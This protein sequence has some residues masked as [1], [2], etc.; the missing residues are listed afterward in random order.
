MPERAAVMIVAH[1]MLRDASI[2]YGAALISRPTAIARPVLLEFVARLGTA[3]RKLGA[4]AEVVS[5][6]SSDD[7]ILQGVLRQLRATEIVIITVGVVLNRSLAG[8]VREVWKTLWAARGNAVDAVRLLK[9][10]ERVMNERALPASQPRDPE[11]MARLA[12]TLP[13]MFKA[14]APKAGVKT[15]AKAGTKA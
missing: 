9:E 7:M 4:S 15:G 2:E 8:A 6:R 11:R 13:A 10:F 14:S 1:A 5:G 3:H 12:T